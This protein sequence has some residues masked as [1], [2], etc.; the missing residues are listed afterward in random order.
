MD[1]N[2]NMYIYIYTSII[3]CSIHMV[4]LL[5]V[6]PPYDFIVNSCYHTIILISLCTRKIPVNFGHEE[7]N[8]T[9]DPQVS[10]E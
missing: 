6:F 5:C 9:V 2:Y 10:L 3:M 4:S 7:F 8:F 1:Y